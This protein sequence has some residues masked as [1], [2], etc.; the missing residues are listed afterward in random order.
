MSE[1]H[2]VYG[3]TF[4]GGYVKYVVGDVADV[5]AALKTVKCQLGIK[6]TLALVHNSAPAA[7][8]VAP[9]QLQGVA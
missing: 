7:T 2:L 3:Q 8:A 4:A 6:R 5:A 1:Q 9:N